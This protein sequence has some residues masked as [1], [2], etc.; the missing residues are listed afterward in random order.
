MYAIFRTSEGEFIAEL[1]FEQV[2]MTVANFVGLA[3][4]SRAW[5]DLSTGSVR[6]APF[7]NGITFHRVVSGFMIQSGLRD[8]PGYQFADEFVNG[9]RHDV[10]G[11]LSMANAGVVTN[12][13]GFFITVAQ[14]QWLDLLHSVFGRIIEGLDN[15]VTI[16]E[17]DTDG[18][19][20]P[21]VD[22]ILYEVEIVRVGEAAEEFDVTAYGLPVVEGVQADIGY[23]GDN[24]MLKF[25]QLRYHQY[26]A[27]FSENLSS[28]AQGTLGFLFNEPLFDEV[29]VSGLKAGKERLFFKTASVD[30]GFIPDHLVGLV[31]KRLTLNVDSD[32]W[33]FVLDFLM[34][35]PRVNPEDELGSATF[36]G[37]P[38]ELV[39]YDWLQADRVGVIYFELDGLPLLWTEAIL[40]F[41]DDDQ[42]TFTAY[43]G[44]SSTIYG[45]FTI[46]DL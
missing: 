44:N 12:G 43:N 16:S 5:L 1:Y 28:W 18:S 45:T 25:P 31:G 41:L 24:L 39:E 3:E 15:V 10:P 9:L 4:G 40:H 42:G 23:V 26:F 20:R 34:A 7:Y 21:I 2:P 38:Y 37:T 27:Y 13:A 14:T 46:E 36:N 29:N 8:G 17:Y 35:G 11:T 33:V 32:G 6:T 30:Y 22:I 19:E